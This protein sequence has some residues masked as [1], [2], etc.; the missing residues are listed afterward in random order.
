MKERPILFSGPMVSAI[1]G[2]IKTQTRRLVKPQPPAWVKVWN[3]NAGDRHFFFDRETDDDNGN[4]W[5]DYD[6]P[7]LR[8]PHGQPGDSL[9]VRETF[10][11]G[12]NDTEPIAIYRDG[13][14]LTKSGI[15]WKRPD[16]PSADS[17]NAIR[18][19]PSIHIPRWASRITLEI[20][21]IRVQQLQ[22]ISEEDAV[23]EGIP[24]FPGHEKIPRMQFASLWDRLNAKRGM[25]WDT[26]PWVWAIT[27]KRSKP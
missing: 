12:A 6:K 8:C 9:W 27:F 15:Y 26:N 23:E 13:C 17:L 10:T 21:E 18:W 20:T 16:E 25:G 1:L 5:P 11:I 24:A 4:H 14:Q 2:G 19:K 3:G 7:G 22:D